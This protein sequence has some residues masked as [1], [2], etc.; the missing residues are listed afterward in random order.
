MKNKILS[1]VPVY[2]DSGWTKYCLGN[3]NHSDLLVI[4][5]CATKEV[6]KVV[7][8]Y[9]KI[10]NS[11]NKM[12]NYV[13][14]QAMEYFLTNKQYDF[15]A[16]ICSDFVMVD[17]WESFCLA[18]FDNCIMLPYQVNTDAKIKPEVR[19][20]D[21]YKKIK[22]GYPGVFMFFSRE[23]VEAVYPIPKGI[24]LWFGDEYIFTKLMKLGYE[25]RVYYELRGLHGNSRSVSEN[26]KAHKTIELD[27]AVWE[28]IKKDI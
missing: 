7:V 15:L 24:K 8:K 14:N 26:P 25:M 16:L 5:D 11:K 1:V 19:L 28:K 2:G 22:G 20:K 9:N 4:D 12:V 10:V 6:K 21:H 27:K 13:W 17:N 23:M 3:I 18:F